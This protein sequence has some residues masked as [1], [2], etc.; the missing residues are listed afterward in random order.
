MSKVM[1][2]RTLL[3]LSTCAASLSL[4]AETLDEGIRDTTEMSE[5]VVTGTR[6]LSCQ[7]SWNKRPGCSPQA[8]AC[9]VMA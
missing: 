1:R 6:L 2:I 3:L 8:E 7:L 4:Q 5:V 9:W